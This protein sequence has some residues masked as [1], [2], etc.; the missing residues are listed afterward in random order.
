MLLQADSKD[1]AVNLLK[2]DPFVTGG[3]WDLDKAEI[4]SVKSGLRVGFVKDSIKAN[5]K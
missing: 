1:E 3:V 5:Y 4:H 2:R